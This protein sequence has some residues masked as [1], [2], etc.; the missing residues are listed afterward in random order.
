MRSAHRW[1]IVCEH[2]RR[3]TRD[4]Y[5]ERH[6]TATALPIRPPDYRVSHGG[7][8]AWF[9]GLSLAQVTWRGLG[10][11]DSKRRDTAIV[12]VNIGSPGPSTGDGQCWTTTAMV[13]VG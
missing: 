12:P 1:G 9:S 5:G 4:K 13:S 3:G 10:S 11:G 6:R 8:A 2:R 7:W